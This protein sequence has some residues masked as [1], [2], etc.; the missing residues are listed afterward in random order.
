MA[1]FAELAARYKRT[2]AS[3][4]RSLEPA[5]FAT[6]RANRF[7]VS[8]KIDGEFWIAVLDGGVA[9]LAAPNG[10]EIREG[11]LVAELRAA[12]ARMKG[13]AVV[14]GELFSAVASGRPRVGDV[15]EALAEG[16]AALDKLRF[17]AFDAIEVDGK[18]AP[19]LYEERLAELE[20]VLPAGERAKVVTTVTTDSTNELR[21]RWDQWV[22]AGGAE[23]LVVRTDDGRIFK[24]KPTFTLDAAIVA[25]T[26][27][28]DTPDEARSVLVALLRADGSF[29]IVG[30]V[31]NLGSSENR[32]SLL[33]QLLKGEC[34][35]SFRHT[36]NDG[37]LYRWVK[38]EL[39]VEIACTDLV[40]EESDGSP[41]ERW[42]VSH[43]SNG[44]SALCPMPGAS[45]LHPVVVRMRT[46]KSVNTTDVRIEQLTERCTVESLQ[47]VAAA[48][49]LPQSAIVRR[50]AWTKAT[51]GKTAVRKLVVWKTNKDEVAPDWPAWVVHFTDYSPDRK[52]PLE[53]TVKTST[54]EREATAIANALVEE[55]IKKGWVGV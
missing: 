44:W 17:H 32:R 38:P 46:D 54:T 34:A 26:T 50:E 16:G 13:R 28:S 15:A 30:S 2:V 20:R 1:E 36:S 55:N 5:E 23:G 6:L 37:V 24:A 7:W 8:E 9:T 11:A 21:A 39:V 48:A 12:A 35:S 22:A 4:Y 42:A 52:T 19:S 45:L 51:K 31:G 47:K 43:D 25:F 27:K 49:T 10:R 40:V 53:R 18:D 14:A 29:Q 41:V 3:R 33:E